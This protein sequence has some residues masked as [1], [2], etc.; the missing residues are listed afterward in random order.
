MDKLKWRKIE[1]HGG[2]SKGLNGTYSGFAKEPQVR[3]QTTAGCGPLLCIEPGL[4]QEFYVIEQV[5][6]LVKWRKQC[7]QHRSVVK[8]KQVKLVFLVYDT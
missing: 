8:L 2:L 1:D 5:P 4:R 6:G 7:L 3:S